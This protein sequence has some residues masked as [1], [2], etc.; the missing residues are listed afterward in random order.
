VSGGTSELLAL[1]VL[2][3]LVVVKKVVVGSMVRLLWYDVSLL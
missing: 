1:E 2:L 3:D